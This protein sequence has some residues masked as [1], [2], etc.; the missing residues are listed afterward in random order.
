MSL[1]GALEFMDER[2]GIAFDAEIVRC[3]TSATR[4]N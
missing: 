4:N 2:A 3:L 1:G